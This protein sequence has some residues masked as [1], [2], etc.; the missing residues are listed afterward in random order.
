MLRRLVASL[1][2]VAFVL[3]L[4][5]PAISRRDPERPPLVTVAAG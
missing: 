4:R 3:E 5:L 2:D 1:D